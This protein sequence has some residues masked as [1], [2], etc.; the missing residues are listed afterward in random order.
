VLGTR[1]PDTGYERVFEVQEQGM[2]GGWKAPPDKMQ[3]LFAW[4]NIDPRPE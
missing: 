3:T 2:K 1:S 4:G